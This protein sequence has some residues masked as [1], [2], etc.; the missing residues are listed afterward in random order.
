VAHYSNALGSVLGCCGLILLAPAGF[1]RS[2][3]ILDFLLCS[4][5]TA[6]ARLSV[7]VL[8]DLSRHSSGAAYR[9]VLIY[10]AGDAGVA[11]LREIRQNRSL[12]YVVVGFVDD[13][14][15]KTGNMIHRAKIFGTGSAL[16]AI[17]KGQGI[18][19]VLIALPSATGAEM[20]A[21]LNRCHEAGL[22]TKQSRGWRK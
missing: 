2:L 17:V 9:R 21:I 15:A 20:T 8:F 1:P 18:E 11:L 3:Y 10:G 12:A 5:M 16:P 6:G 19:L 13:N 22:L 7:R 4:V 14:P